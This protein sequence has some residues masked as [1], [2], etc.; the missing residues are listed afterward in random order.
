[1]KKTTLFLFTLVL[2]ASCKEKAIDNIKLEI[3]N[4]E[5]YFNGKYVNNN[6]SNQHY[7][8]EMDR[9][10]ARNILTWR[11][12]NYS[13]ENYLFIINEDANLENPY[14]YYDHNNFEITDNKNEKLKV[15]GSNILWSGDNPKTGSLY[16]CFQYYDSIR[17]N[18]YKLKGVKSENCIVNSEY[19]KSSFVL[20]P[21]ECKTF[22]TIISLPILKEIEPIPAQSQI[23]F[24]PIYEGYKFNLSFKCDSTKIQQSLQDYQIQD[25]KV[26]K[27]RIYNGNLISN[28]IP[29]K[30]RR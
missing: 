21:N 12:T 7:K 24:G 3:L 30:D 26:N 18:Y 5:I 22:K 16:G 15:G 9:K 23:G 17:A 20:H 13:N 27:I 4:K 11:L 8:S 25:L 6:S 2:F 28:K 19:V 1:M 10:N 14:Y 29:L